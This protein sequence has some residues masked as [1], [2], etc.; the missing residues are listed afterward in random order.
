MSQS[1][2]EE[3]T[4]DIQFGAPLRQ[5]REAR[6]MRVE[7]ISE[8][9]K[10]PLGIIEAIEKS[11]VE[12]L[13]PPT[14]TKGYLRAY[15]RFVEIADQ[16]VLQC[17]DNA[18]PEKKIPG[19]RSRLPDETN[20]QSPIVRAVTYVLL[21]CGILALVYGG[22]QY[23]RG[24]ADEMEAHVKVRAE[25]HADQVSSLDAPRLKPI[26]VVQHA[27]MS[28]SGELVVAPEYRTVVTEKEKVTKTKP[29]LEPAAES[30]S[31]VVKDTGQR[32]HDTIRF[33]AKK[34]AWLEVRDS[35]GKRLHYDMIPKNE[36]ISLQGKA[37]FKLSLGNARSTQVEINGLPVDMGR[38][39]KPNNIAQFSATVVEKN[40][41]PT[42]HLKR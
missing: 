9:M 25:K 20:S 21:I 39:I 31:P 41:Q 5:A 14:F 17:Y 32:E 19:P 28:E 11:A 6:K 16:D 37:P 15:A 24:K 3:I 18:V 8:L 38:Y 26:P 13:P 22:I 36:W 42:V 1:D 23:Y 35:T 40:G 7:E 4:L 2:N 33:L 29:T 30:V 10:V 27:R 12:Q 34:G